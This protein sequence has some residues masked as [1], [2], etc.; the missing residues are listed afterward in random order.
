[1]TALRFGV[2]NSAHGNTQMP[3]WGDLFKTIG[4][5]SDSV[6]QRISNLT[7]YLKKMQK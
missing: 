4:P 6:Q 7:D 2:E 5:S 3:I 1:M